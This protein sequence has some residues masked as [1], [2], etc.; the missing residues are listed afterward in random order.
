L[1]GYLNHDLA[2]FFP[3]SFF[4]KAC[5]IITISNPTTPDQDMARDERAFGLRNEDESVFRE[6]RQ[7]KQVKDDI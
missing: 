2:V 4:L 6:S 1:R 7:R 5:C 3:S